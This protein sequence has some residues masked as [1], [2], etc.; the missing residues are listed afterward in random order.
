VGRKGG[1]GEL[2]Q[3]RATK[4]EMDLLGSENAA[5]PDRNGS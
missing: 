1:R 5:V 2:R 4:K 3:G